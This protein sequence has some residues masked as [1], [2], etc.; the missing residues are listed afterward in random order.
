MSPPNQPGPSPG[1]RVGDRAIYRLAYRGKWK[2]SR[3]PVVV[4]CKV[5]PNNI[6]IRLV[7]SIGSVVYTWVKPDQ[8]RKLPFPPLDVFG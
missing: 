1:F 5:L 3:L 4:V 6:Q 7:T 2:F 8:L